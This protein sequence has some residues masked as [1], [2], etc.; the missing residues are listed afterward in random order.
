MSDINLNSG[1][2]AADKDQTIAPM[3]VCL[4]SNS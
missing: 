4:V 2:D 3:F 1:A